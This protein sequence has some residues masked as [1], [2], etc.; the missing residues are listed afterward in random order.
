MAPPFRADPC[1]ELAAAGGIAEGAG[2]HQAGRISAEELRRV[3]D[4]AIRDVVR[5]LQE[6]RLYGVTG[7]E[8]RVNAT[9]SPTISL[10]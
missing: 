6:I 8:L 7:G 2:E 9:I 1:R 10:I 5:M 4:A 3:E